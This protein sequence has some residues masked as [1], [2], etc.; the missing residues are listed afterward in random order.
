MTDERNVTDNVPS[1][2]N[3]GKET[4]GVVGKESVGK[5]ELG[6][7]LFGATPMTGNFRGT[8]VDVERYESDEFVFVDTPGILLR[9]DTET[10]RTAISAAKEAETVLLVVRAANIDDDLEDLLPLVQG[11]VGVI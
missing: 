8:T 7:G 10:T 2:E 4:V 5:S 1:T 3:G 6:A 9:T 11:K